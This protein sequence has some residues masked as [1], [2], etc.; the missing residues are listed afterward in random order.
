MIYG[1]HMDPSVYTQIKRHTE[2]STKI[3]LENSFPGYG[4]SLTLQP[5]ENHGHGRR[6][7]LFAHVSFVRLIDLFV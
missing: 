2:Y 1:A 4:L 3:L 6:P 5:T 7:G